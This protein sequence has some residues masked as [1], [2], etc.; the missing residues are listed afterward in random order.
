MLRDGIMANELLDD[1]WDTVQ[2]ASRTLEGLGNICAP[3]VQGAH[4]SDFLI[5]DGKAYIVYTANDVRPHH[6]ANW[7]ECY[8][9]LSIV[10]IKS[11]DV[12][13]VTPIATSEMVCDNVSLP[14][15][16]CFVPRIIRRDARTLRCYFSSE[17][18]GVR[19]AQVWYRDFDLENREFDN[20][21]Y[22]VKLKIDGE[23][24]PMQPQYFY[25]YA[26]RRGLME[27]P[28]DYGVY[29]I[30]SFKPFDGRI[31]AVINNYPIGQNALSVVNEAL[32]TFEL[33]GTLDEPHDM[34][35]TESS[36]NRLPDG[37][38]LAITRRED[39]DKSYVFSQSPDGR[40]WAPHEP[41]EPV[42][43]GSNSKPTFDRFNGVY[44]LGWQDAERCNDV[45]RSIFNIDV[46]TD[47]KHWERKYRFETEASFQYPVFRE[48]EGA[49]YLTV[50]QGSPP[51]GRT[52]FIAFGRLE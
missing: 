5:V 26:V 38:W 35:L 50:S 18:P 4:D 25:E 27:K 8:A 42:I 29:F 43:G 21:I 39:G 32:D 46:S 36:V 44:Y 40:V 14:V 3:E 23:V 17:Q 16:A 30:D 10:D 6:N 9:A 47:C 1:N 31:Y 2:S 48:Y 15:G 34:K 20:S 7:P 49:I 45:P 28:H 51:R 37:T 19:Q 41:R 52:E 24:V 22:P 11:H 13:M 12:E 33:L